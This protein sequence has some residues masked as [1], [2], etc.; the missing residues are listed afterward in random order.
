M[1]AIWSTS[2]DSTADFIERRLRQR[3]LNPIRIN[4]DT[5]SVTYGLEELGHELRRP[6]AD[7]LKDGI[8]ELR[9]KHGGMSI[10]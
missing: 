10:F 3:D 9:A 6:E 1:I 7:F 4:T 2:K 5:Y 8:Y